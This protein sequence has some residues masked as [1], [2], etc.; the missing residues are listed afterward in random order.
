MPAC[1]GMAGIVAVVVAADVWAS[2]TKRPTISAT[3]ADLLDHPVG[4]PVAVG[5]LVGL[6][7][8]LL[9]DPIIRQLMG[10]PNE[11]FPA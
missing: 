8:H 9:A 11:I 10:A 3:I 7:W 2:K 4:G 6:G 1:C 5:G